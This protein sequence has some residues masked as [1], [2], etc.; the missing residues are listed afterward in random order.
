MP[1]WRRQ[2]RCCWARGRVPDDPTG[3]RPRR[4]SAVG[5]GRDRGDV[6]RQDTAAEK[7]PPA[8]FPG[9]AGMDRRAAGRVELLLQT[10]GPEGHAGRL[11]A[12][13]GHGRGVRIRIQIEGR[14]KCENPVCLAG[15]RLFRFFNAHAIGRRVWKYLRIAKQ[16]AA[17]ARCLS[18][19]PLTMEPNEKI[20]SSRNSS[21]LAS[22]YSA[23]AITQ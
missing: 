4:R 16:A 23:A 21:N 18:V 7:P 20:F 3:G 2:A 8:S 10:A 22:A 1:A 9:M 6:G 14:V 17:A 13:Q 12:I 15:V 19:C 11:G 5:H